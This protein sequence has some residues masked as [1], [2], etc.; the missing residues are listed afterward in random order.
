MFRRPARSAASTDR[1]KTRPEKATA[2]RAISAE[3]Q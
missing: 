3:T 1:K 2:G